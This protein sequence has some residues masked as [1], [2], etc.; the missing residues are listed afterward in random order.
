M[1]INVRNVFATFVATLMLKGGFNKRLFTNY[2]N[3]QIFNEACPPYTEALKRMDT[4]QIYNL[5]GCVLIKAMKRTKRES[6][7]LLVSTHLSTLMWSQILRKH[8]LH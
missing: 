4:T 5:I 8:S 2:K 7:K 3:A 6:G 1:S